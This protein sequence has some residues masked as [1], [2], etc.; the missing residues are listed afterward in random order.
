MPGVETL[1]RVATE[2]V[3]VGD[4]AVVW[5]LPFDLPALAVA[6]PATAAALECLA[7]CRDETR[8][9]LSQGWRGVYW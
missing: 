3:D 9:F 4:S 5:L 2:V 7:H 6:T 1:E 8:R